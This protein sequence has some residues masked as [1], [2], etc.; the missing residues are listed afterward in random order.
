M[1]ST[2][3]RALLIAFSFLTT[4]PVRY[5]G[6]VS[7]AE[8]RQSLY[9]YPVV[10]LAIG[11]ILLVATVFLPDASLLGAALVLVLWIVLTGALHLDGLADCADAWIG[12]LGSREKT[13][14]ILN[15]P[16]AGAI[17]VV[18]LISLLLLKL[19]AMAELLM[20]EHSG[21]LLVAPVIARTSP[22]I[23]FATTPYVRHA[24]IG[25]HLRI[26]H[27]EQTAQYSVYLAVTLFSFLILGFSAMTVIV[28]AL[29]VTLGVIVAAKKRLGGFTGDV[30]G[31][32]IELVEISACVVLALTV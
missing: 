9:W 20:A 4:L 12:G 29:L 5:P 15:D 1:V 11:L 21:F 32:L 16:N 24:G 13:L 26:D 8:G 19:L 3:L 28:V 23:L 2:R 14:R 18:T 31:A 7:A 27:Q 22:M 25:S 6:E 17:A 10:G 30:A